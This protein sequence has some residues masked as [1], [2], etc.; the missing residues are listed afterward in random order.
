MTAALKVLLMVGCITLAACTQSVTFG[1]KPQTDRLSALVRGRSTA[2]DVLLALGEP[3][4]RGAARF[5]DQSDP[6]R[7]DVLFYE[8]VQ[9]G[10]S[11]VN[12]KMLI[13]FMRDGMYDGHLWFSSVDSM[14]AKKG[15]VVTE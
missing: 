12:L 10:G 13:V 9:S 6:A 14:Q 1:A 11:V 15:I 7:R 2:A 4:G 3:R 8:F 5:A